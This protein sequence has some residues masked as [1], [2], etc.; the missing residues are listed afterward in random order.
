MVTQPRGITTE[1]VLKPGGA[2]RKADPKLLSAGDFLEVVTLF[3]PHIYTE[4]QLVPEVPL[5]RR[6]QG[7]GGGGGGGEG[8]HKK[9][10]ASELSEARGVRGGST[11]G[12]KGLGHLGLEG[13]NMVLGGD[14]RGWR[15]GL[16]PRGVLD[17]TCWGLDDRILKAVGTVEG[18]AF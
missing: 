11:V 9:A 10:Q 13:K 5:S 14:Y 4:C 2:Q 17:S 8:T 18:F 12:R 1:D 3:V 15:A 16:T 7:R 6:M